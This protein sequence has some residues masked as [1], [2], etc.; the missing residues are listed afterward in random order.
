M[1]GSDQASAAL[2]VFGALLRFYR[3]RVNISQERLGKHV[4]YSKSQ[5]AMVEAGKRLPSDRFVVGADELLGAQGALRAA[6]EALAEIKRFPEGFQ[7]Y[8]EE[9]AQAVIIGSY[10]NSLIPGLLQTPAYARAVYQTAC[11]PLEEEFI[12]KKVAERV[13]R[14]A[15]FT[16]K[17]KPKVSF[18]IEETVLSRPL[19]GRPVLKEALHHMLGLTQHP[20]VSLQVMP[21]DVRTHSGLSGP[22]VLVDTADYRRFVYVEGQSGN[23]MLTEP[24]TTSVL[25]EKY[26]T[27]REQA[28][29]VEESARWIEEAVGNL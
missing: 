1:A 3:L 13:E 25:F 10:E 11:P 15:I 28:R 4:G 9:E 18:V 6:A 23:Y 22:M 24:S 12:D 17:P 2:A 14:A 21:N 19:G 26:A 7:S 16:R 20:G 8:L 29:N 5:V 27:L